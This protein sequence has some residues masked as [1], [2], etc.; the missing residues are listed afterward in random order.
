MTSY[1]NRRPPTQVYGATSHNS[2]VLS[3]A[4]RR[5]LFEES[6]LDP[7]DIALGVAAATLPLFGP[8]PRPEIPDQGA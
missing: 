6:G 8:P 4:H 2:S 3:E 7:G 5:M 1:P